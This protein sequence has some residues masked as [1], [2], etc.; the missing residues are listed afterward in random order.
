MKNTA[1]L[2]EELSALKPQPRCSVGRLLAGSSQEVA[3]A[4]ERVV[5]DSRIPLRLVSETLAR[6]GHPIDFGMV[7]KHRLSLCSCERG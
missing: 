2:V 3:Q 6:H 5:M 1:Q 4:I 7:R